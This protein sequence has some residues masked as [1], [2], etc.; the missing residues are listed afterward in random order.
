MIEEVHW[1]EL[2]EA[3]GHR[4]AAPEL[5]VEALTHSSYRN[6]QPEAGPDNERLEFLGDAVLGA[7]MSHLLADAY[8]D[9]P[10]GQLT[11]YKAVLVSE[12]GL[13]QIARD[14]ELGRY[15]RLGRGE[16][17]GGGRAKSS[18]LANAVEAIL[19]AIYLDAGFERVFDLVRSLYGERIAAVGAE[20]GSTDF[21]TQL[22]ELVQDHHRELPRYVIV[23]VTG[24]DHAR[25]FEAAVTVRGEELAR[26][27]GRSKKSAEQA[28]ARAAY[29]GVTPVSR[30]PQDS[31]I[32]NDFDEEPTD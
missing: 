17:C 14:L 3:L 4:F 24:P 27:H 30:S 10:E 12:R 32:D 31:G 5:L 13:L 7:I 23:S 15:L 29:E 20:A 19:A 11:R 2:A 21:K 8:P 16:A 18:M 26:G 22:Q 1:E 25:E 28:A 9:A 6:E